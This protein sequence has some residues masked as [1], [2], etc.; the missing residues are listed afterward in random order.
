MTMVKK[1]ITCLVCACCLPL[2][3]QQKEAKEI[4]DQTLKAFQKAGGV[5]LTF[6]ADAFQKE[7]K[8]GQA[9]GTL[10]LKGDK[11]VLKTSENKTWFD[12]KTQWTYLPGSDEVNITVPTGEE[13]Q[14]LNPYAFLSVYKEGYSYEM[15]KRK[16]FSGQAVKEVILNSLDS[17]NIARLKLF[18]LPGNWQIVYLEVLLKDGTLNKITIKNYKINQSYKDELFVFDEKKHPG[19]E[20]IDLR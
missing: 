20:V 9:T 17:G 12:G 5:M 1:I 13:L 8:L 15:G 10:Q 4:L 3:G 19:V 7:A 18:V 16:N 6:E 2:W 14:D 11:F